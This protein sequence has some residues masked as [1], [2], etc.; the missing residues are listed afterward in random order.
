[1]S[2]NLY[3]YLPHFALIL[4][5]SIATLGSLTVS[6]A[7]PTAL[8]LNDKSKVAIVL[9]QN[10]T[11]PEQTAV[12]ELDDYL[13]K[14]TGGEFTVSNEPSKPA[15]PAIYVGNTAFAKGAGIAVNTLASEEW[16]I[17]T[18]AGNL[19]L[20]GGGTRGTLYAAY[21]FLE[22]N[23]GVRWW[24]PWEE[25]IPSRRELRFTQLDKRGKPAFSYR[26]IYML[27]GNDGGRFALRSRLNR[28]GDASIS[29]EYGGSRDYGPPY[30]VHT[31][32]K[33]LLPE[34]YFK[35][36]PDWYLM[37]GEGT[38]T[39]NN[40]QLHM[41]N[42]EMRQEFLKL[43]REIIRK[44][45]QD[46]KEKGLPA[47]DVFSVSQEDS[48]NTFAGPNDAKLLAENDG[49]ESAI[50]IDF[51]N[52]LAD[53]IKDEFPGVYIDTLAYFNG[54]KAPTTI[55]PRDNV[56]VR[57]TDTTSNVLLPV[58]AERNHAFRNNVV[59]WS[60]ITK[61]LRVWDY[62]ITF[63]HPSLPTPTLNTY[64]P[65]LQF[66]RAHN[67]DGMFIEFEHPLTADMRDMKVWIL[68]KLLENPSL[69]TAAL[70]R[71][72]T[73]GY[74]G[75]AAPEVREYLAALDRSVQ[76]TAKQSAM[77][78]L[79]NLFPGLSE[80]TYLT[81]EFFV[82]ADRIYEKAAAKVVNDPVLSRRLRRARFAV[83]DALLM[84][85]PRLVAEWVREGHTLESFA[86]NRDKIAAR[87]LQ[88][89]N[90][91]IDLQLPE[92]ER[93]AARAAAAVQSAKW[94]TGPLYTPTPKKFGDVPF[95]KLTVYGA[96]DTRNYADMARVVDDPQAES[97]QA[98]RYEIPDAELEKYKLPMAWGVYQVADNKHLLTT[99][100]KAEE[101]TNP[102][103]QWYKMGDVTLGHAKLAYAFFTWSWNIQV[104]LD[105]AFD[106][107]NPQQQFEIWGNIK[108]E[109]PAF[110][111]GKAEDKNSIYVERLVLV[112][113]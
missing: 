10:A 8:S 67:V 113:K 16:R 50:L 24:S 75:A 83:D 112:K 44:S 92:A 53:G 58:T 52:Y 41:S 88:T 69:N 48:G 27:Y 99:T 102:G 15:A 61:N 105:N 86:F 100:I 34:K 98:T 55:R 18:Q 111:H 39:W 31:F 21:R 9:P 109:G 91:Q 76:K 37:T 54:E 3:S 107:N 59:A 35:D 17:K 32:N 110:P 89:Q 22:D 6:E 51:V 78:D 20:V 90:E 5:A 94:T 65:D 60:K 43:L 70:I 63:R 87:H 30:H 36:H 85:F 77:P 71:E 42:P 103:Y 93:V 97:G 4:S 11:L 82:E 80:F 28:E 14:I 47:P 96:R 68:S 101:V 72:F 56:I 2:Q 106:A 12:R 108:F 64:A 66:L 62:D 13:T 23:A 79:T 73:D 104:D 57:L 38:P 7:Q 25:K 81:Q 40:S 49:A 95:A 45:H 74:Y 33:I 84:S 29:A 1:M 26:D 46:A 19:I